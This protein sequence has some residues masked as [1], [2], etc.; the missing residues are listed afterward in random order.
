M[1]LTEEVWSTQIE[2]ECDVVVVGS[3]AAGISL[4]LE[5]SKSGVQVILLEGGGDSF[6]GESQDCYRGFS[7]E[8]N[9]PF[10]LSRS[11]LRFLGGSTNC[12]AGGCGELDSQ[13]F[14]TRPW[15]PFS[16]W[17]IKKEDLNLYYQRA[18][19]FLD[20]NINRIRKP[21]ENAGLPDFE[22]FELRS[23][24]YTRK[25]KFSTHFKDQLNNNSFIKLFLGANLTNLNR[26]VGDETVSTAEIR[27]FNKAKTSVKAKIYVLA[28]GGIENARI[29]LN[30]GDSNFEA[31]GNYGDKLGRFFCDHPIAPCATVIGLDGKLN[32]MKYEDRAFWQPNKAGQISAPFYRIPYDLQEKYSILNTAIQFHYQEPELGP[33]E[34]AAWQLK[35][36]WSDS[37][38]FSVT[39]KDILAIAESPLELIA[40]IRN[41]QTKKGSRIALRFQIEQAPNPESRVTLINEK[42]SLGVK[43]IKLSWKFSNIERHTIDVVTAYVAQCLQNQKIGTLRLDRELMEHR[44][45]LPRDL[46]GGQH[47]SCTTRMSETDK[48]GV[49]D[50]NLRVFHTKNLFVCGSSV[51]PTNGWVNPTMTII[52]LS[53]R[54]ANFIVDDIKNSK[55]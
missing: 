41:R 51:F 45:D 46:R 10:G 30:S 35:N 36:Y 50:K 28:C 54:L 32:E 2:H 43:R 37:K 22:G 25:V 42:D 24:E 38:E 8:R 19:E 9:L 13:D 34:I 39:A 47:H 21:L 17:P 49:V 23:L 18:A 1:I 12:W 53:L 5:L 6:T 14:Y 15:I 11:R 7:T 44:S 33:A 40:A 3:G 31:F 26:S 4:A 29:L 16:G 48:L 27:S 52:A 55:F 20:I